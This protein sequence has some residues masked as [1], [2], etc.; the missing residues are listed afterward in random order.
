ML[1]FLRKIVPQ[2]LL[3]FYHKCWAILGNIIYRF[4][5]RKLKII[6]VTGTNGKTTTVNMI[7]NILEASGEKV[8]LSSTIN[9]WDGKNKWVNKSKLTVLGYF[10]IPRLL[11]QMVKNN[12]TYAVLEVSSHAIVQNRIWGIPFDIAVLTNVTHDHLDY[13]HNFSNY[14]DTKGR[15]FAGLSGSRN[16]GIPKTIV[17]NADDPTYS[18]FI[19]FRADKKLAYSL[20]DKKLDIPLNK[21]ERIE[22][23]KF[24]SSFKVITPN[25]NFDLFLKIPGRFNIANSL[26][27]I[28]VTQALDISSKIIKASLEKF[29]GIPGR[30]EAVHEG[31]D[32]LVLVDYAH[33]PDALEKIYKTLKPVTTGK[34]IAVL[35]A[36]GDRDKTKRPILGKLAGKL[37]NY[38]II[39]DED[40]Y[41]EDPENIMDQVI[42][43][44]KDSGKKEKQNYWKILD[45]GKAIEFAVNIAQKNDTVII[46]GKGCEQVMVTNQGKIPWDDRKIA[47][48]SIKNKI[49][50]V[51]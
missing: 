24:S 15:L 11:R 49:H 37:A 39:T 16:K 19:K 18:Y 7:A 50:L 44:V 32:F 41:T 36:T 27:A 43:G 35:G 22:L 14:R 1:N 8:G 47:K 13:H 21:A 4:P 10:G 2:P 48:E 42:K 30:L 45:R 25:N 3:L 34:L 5:G 28:C 17:V 9:F 46:T 38:V 33:T 23:Q 12:C 26:A 20:V 40:P 29:E 6:G 51:K 31:Q